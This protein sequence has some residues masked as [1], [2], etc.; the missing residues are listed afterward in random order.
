MKELITDLIDHGLEEQVAVAGVARV[1]KCEIA[2]LQ[3]DVGVL[4]AQ[5]RKMDLI[6][7]D[8]RKIFR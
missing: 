5:Q 3:A 2:E 4:S 6:G 8:E 1:L 7:A